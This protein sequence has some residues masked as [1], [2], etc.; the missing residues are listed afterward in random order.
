MV[1]SIAVMSASG[2]G[3]QGVSISFVTS[4]VKDMG[5]LRAIESLNKI[6]MPE[7]PVSIFLEKLFLVLFIYFFKKKY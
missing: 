6:K 7:M 5:N 3:H 2:G 1:N 4:K